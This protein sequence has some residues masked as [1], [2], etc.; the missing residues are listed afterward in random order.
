MCFAIA[1][2]V[3]PGIEIINEGCVGKSFPTFWE[4]FEGLS[5]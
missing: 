2:L 3:V 4:V 1:G 5:K